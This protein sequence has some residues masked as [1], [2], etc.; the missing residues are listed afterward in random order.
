[1]HSAE[2]TMQQEY[3]NKKDTTEADN[4]KDVKITE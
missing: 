4:I 1:M 2:P 3:I